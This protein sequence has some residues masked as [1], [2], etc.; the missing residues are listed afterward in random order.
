MVRQIGDRGGGHPDDLGRGV[1]AGILV[2]A[3]AG[4]LIQ[5]EA[6]SV[7]PCGGLPGVEPDL[8]HLLD[9]PLLLI[10]QARCLDVGCPMLSL[11]QPFPVLGGVHHDAFDRVDV[12]EHVLA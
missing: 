5:G 3:D 6:R 10:D 8:A 2:H 9:G 7:G 1:I 11:R 4:E 12:R